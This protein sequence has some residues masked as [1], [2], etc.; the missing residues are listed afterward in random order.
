V[1]GIDADQYS[2]RPASQG[3]SRRKLWLDEY[4]ACNRV[5]EG[6]FALDGLLGLDVYEEEADLFFEDLSSRFIDDDVF[7]R[8]L[9]F[10]NVLITRHQAYFTKEPL[11][12]IAET[13]IANVTSFE[14]TGRSA[15]EVSVEKIAR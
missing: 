10:P 12:N 15:H 11:S 8:L 5:S 9:T 2:M 1:S 4:R 6:K 13:T 7:A 3:V 14:Q